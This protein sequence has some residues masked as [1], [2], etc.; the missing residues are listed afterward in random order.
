MTELVDVV[1]PIYELLVGSKVAEI[2]TVP[3]VDGR[4]EHVTVALAKTALFLH[5]GIT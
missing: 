1:A 4:Y 3:R 2:I 5:P